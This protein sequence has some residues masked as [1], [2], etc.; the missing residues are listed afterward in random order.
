MFLGD[1]TPNP[2]H[3]MM[4]VA[5]T[6]GSTVEKHERPSKEEATLVAKVI[7]FPA[8]APIKIAGGEWWPRA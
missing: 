7:L 1:D 5:L 6:E 2:M 3:R 8:T 4:A